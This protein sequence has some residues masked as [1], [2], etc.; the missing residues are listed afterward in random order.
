MLAHAKKRKV[1]AEGRGFKK[2]WTTK[3]LFTEV[4]SKPV[5]LGCG[6]QVAVFKEYNVSRH[7][8]TKHAEKYR[9]LTDAERVRISEHLLAELGKQQGYFTKLHAAQDAATKT[10]FVTSHK[11]AKNCKPFSEREF[12]KECLVESVH[13]LL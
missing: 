13:H 4:G 6:E 8:E 10:S 2:I 1:D 7:Y 11:I 5:C 12:V 3:Y 9:H